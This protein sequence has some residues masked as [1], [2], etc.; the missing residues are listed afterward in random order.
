MPN[1]NQTSSFTNNYSQNEV[2]RSQQSTKND[3]KLTQRSSSTKT[4]NTIFKPYEDLL[5]QKMMNQN[6][7]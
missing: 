3:E 5:E 1:L 2:G 4:K 7:K 6:Y